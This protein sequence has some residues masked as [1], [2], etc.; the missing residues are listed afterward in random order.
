MKTISRCGSVREVSHTIGRLAILDP[1]LDVA[2]CFRCDCT[3]RGNQTWVGDC[4]V[5]ESLV[6]NDDNFFASYIIGDFDDNNED[7]VEGAIVPLDPQLSGIRCIIE[8]VF[9]GVHWGQMRIKV[10]QGV[11]NCA[12]IVAMRVSVWTIIGRGCHGYV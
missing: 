12:P 3:T 11:R 8:K 10:V 7:V 5:S 4:D 2:D 6:V 1:V 9:A